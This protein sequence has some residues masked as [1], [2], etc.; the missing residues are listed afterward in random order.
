MSKKEHE[1]MSEQT[2]KLQKKMDSEKKALEDKNREMEELMEEMKREYRDQ[3]GVLTE[4]SAVLNEQ[5]NDQ[6]DK[7]KQAEKER[8]KNLQKVQELEAATGNIA[9]LK[10]ENKVMAKALKEANKEMEVAEVKYKQEMKKRKK[11]HNEIED[12]K[13]KIRVFARVRP[14]MG[15]E[16]KRGDS[17]CVAIPDEM[18]VNIDTKN[19]VKAYHFDTC[20]G[21]ESTQEEVFDETARLA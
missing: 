16:V 21:P 1:K 20:F 8:K 14:L 7:L 2:K 11:L 17:N 12:M 4:Q 15:N 18:T 3:I 9:D 6:D 5:L 13:G 10:K 19:G